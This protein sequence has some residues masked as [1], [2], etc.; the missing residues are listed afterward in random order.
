MVQAFQD[1]ERSGRYQEKFLAQ[2]RLL[3][4][5]HAAARGQD[6]YL[7]VIEELRDSEEER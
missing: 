5:M 6:V 1:V 3:I 2:L 4:L 7:R